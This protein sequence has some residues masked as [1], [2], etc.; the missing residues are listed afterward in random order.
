MVGGAAGHHEHLV[1]LAQ[2]LVGQPLLV[3][4]DAAVDEVAQ[5]CVGHRGGLLGDL[6]EHEVLVATLFGGRK[7]PVDVELAGIRVVRLAVEVGDPITVGG[8]HHRLVLAEFDGVA[9]VFDERRD[10][11]GDE[12]LAVANAEHQRGR[13]PGGHDRARLVGIG[14]D[15][16]EVT[17]EAAQHGQHGGDKVA[18]GVTAGVLACDQV[19]GDLAVGVAGEIPRRRLPA[20]DAVP[21]SSR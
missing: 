11:G 10:I 5:Q 18:S 4:H 15:Q 17:L 7:V 12:H 20:R 19:H 13:A 16:R 1:D 6:L 21:R 8:D 2:F 9:G 14:E 3:E